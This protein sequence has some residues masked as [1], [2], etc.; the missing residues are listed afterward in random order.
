MEVKKYLCVDAI[1]G[2]T[3]G[4]TYEGKVVEDGW[5]RVTSDWNCEQEFKPTRFKEI[6]GDEKVSA[7]ESTGDLLALVPNERR[8][9]A[10]NGLT[11]TAVLLACQTLEDKGLTVRTLYINPTMVDEFMISCGQWI[12]G[13]EWVDGREAYRIAIPALKYRAYKHKN[14]DSYVESHC[15]KNFILVPDESM[16]EDRVLIVANDKTMAKITIGWE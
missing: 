12:D 3:Y 8:V 6:N 11:Q 15:A 9:H 1:P 7:A 5:I 10:A 13:T 16:P 14:A 2:I 4:K